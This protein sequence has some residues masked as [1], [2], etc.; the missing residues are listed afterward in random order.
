M[1]GELVLKW[2]KPYTAAPHQFEVV[3]SPEEGVTEAQLERVAEIQQMLEDEW[4][5]LRGLASHL[6][7]PPVG[8]GWGLGDF[9]TPPAPPEVFETSESDSFDD[10][11]EASTEPVDMETALRRLQDKFGP[12]NR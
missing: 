1:P 11:T 6:P 2:T 12:K 9:E 5:G 4:A 7:S 10:D 8:S 3:H